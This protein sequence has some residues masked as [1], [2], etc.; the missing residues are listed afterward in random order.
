MPPTYKKCLK[1]KYSKIILLF[2]LYFSQ[3]LPFGFQ[4]TALPIY[5]RSQNVSLTTIG[6]AGALSIPWMLKI[7]FAPFVDRYS[8]KSV[9][10]RKSWIIPLQC[11]LFITILFASY[12]SPGKNLALLLVSVFFMN[13]IA[14]TQDIA[15]DGLAVDLLGPT[16]LG[17]G[18]AVQV[19]G[20]KAGMLISGGVLVWLSGFW[21]WNGLFLSMALVSLIPLILILFYKEP[22]SDA[23]CN[24]SFYNI[25]DIIN[26]VIEAFKLPFSVWLIV[27]IATYKMG[28]I[29][30]DMMFKPFL[31]DIGFMPSQI[32]LWTGTYGMAASIAGSLSG[33]FLVSKIFLW[34]SLALA[35]ILRIIPLAFEWYLT[36]ISPQELHV[37]LVT[38]AEHFFGGMLTTAMFAYMMWCVD[39]KIGATHYTIFASIE[40]FG[41]SPGALVSGQIA[42]TF[43]YSTLFAMGTILSLPVL[44]IITKLKKDLTP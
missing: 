42:E 19:V 18:N 27:F 7:F 21:G 24:A 25:K 36:I 5:L 10:R 23:A 34:R 12:I 31:F 40:V 6:F 44:F 16:E 37:I 3:G 14:A 20:Y 26:H 35:C 22:V 9:G 17:H 38:I 43:G 30:I 13:L 15:V 4:A 32:G 33:G 39:K 8:I 41:K 2:F 29:M 11:L 28:E 1:I